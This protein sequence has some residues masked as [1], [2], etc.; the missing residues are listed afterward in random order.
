M[1]KLG[2]KKAALEAELGDPAT[3]QD[4]HKVKALVADQAYVAKELDELESEWLEKNA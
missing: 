3:Y 1:A 2:A 4:P